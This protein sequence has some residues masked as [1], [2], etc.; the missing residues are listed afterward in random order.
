MNI[1]ITEQQFRELVKKQILNEGVFLNGQFK[2]NKAMLSYRQGRGYSHDFKSQDSVNTEKMEKNNDD[3]Y[4]VP[5]KGGMVSYNITSINGE[6]VMHYFKHYWDSQKATMSIKNR[7]GKEVNYQLYME[8]NEFNKFLSTFINKV[9]AVVR[10]YIRSNKL[11]NISKISIYPVPSSSRFNESMA[12]KLV[13]MN[14]GGLP[15]QVIDQRLFRKDT[16]NIQRDNDFIE[17]NKEYY[18]SSLSGGAEGFSSPAINYVDK[19]INKLRAIQGFK[20]YIEDMN[21]CVSR[22][23][24][25]YSNYIINKSQSALQS[26]AN[27]YRGYFDDMHLAI[28]QNQYYNP[29]RDKS[30]SRLHFKSGAK[31]IGLKQVSEGRRPTDKVILW[32][33]DT[34][35]PESFLGN[36]LFNGSSYSTKRHYASILKRPN[37]RFVVV[38][39]FEEFKNYILKN[40]L[41]TSV[42]FDRD[43]GGAKEGVPNGTAAAKW[44][45]DYCQKTGQKIPDYW[46]HSANDKAAGEIKAVMNGKEIP[47]SDDEKQDEKF[48]KFTIKVWDLIKPLLRGI[49]STVTG[50]PYVICNIEY[51]KHNPFEIK[52]LNNAER[53]GIKNFF[54]IDNEILE[55]ER[56]RIN[57]TLFVIFDDNISGGAT[58]SDICVQAKN[59]GIQNILPITFGKM[60]TKWTYK[61]TSINRPTDKNGNVG[62]FNT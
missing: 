33:D 40:G 19:A 17:K 43:I 30:D 28:A 5:L 51:H 16:T 44:L 48:N 7:N 23:R 57:G 61:G 27:S 14:I 59:A 39:S 3:T 36:N 20:P 62:Y 12:R 54:A 6:Y 15:I 35:T 37:V 53:M 60:A 9:S 55:Q 49:K 2:G 42:S 29:I 34:R 52:T 8:E 50:K 18:N 21:E 13:N 31:S 45:Y 25:Y 38:K 22:M 11:D 26:L 41:P 32:L 46:V 58:L 47:E 10:H 56:E 4:I 24:Q 1:I